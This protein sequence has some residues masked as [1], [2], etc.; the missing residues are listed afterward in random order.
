MQDWAL[1]IA[2]DNPADARPVPLNP[3]PLVAGQVRMR[4]ERFALTANN[5]TYATFGRAMR[6]WDFFPGDDGRGRLPVWG[7]ASVSES[8]HPDVTVGSRWYGYLPAASQWVM[9]PGDVSARGWTDVAEHRQPLPSVY[10]RYLPAEPQTLAAEQV[11]MV[12]QPLY[13]TAFLLDQVVAD[14]EQP[15]SGAQVLST[16]ASSKTAIAMA[17]CLA[18]REDVTHI[19]LTSA[20][21]V[22]FVEGLGL[23]DRV[24]AYDALSDLDARTPSVIVDFAGDSS[25]NRQLHSHL[26]GGLQ[27]NLRVGGAH[28]TASAPPKDLPPPK[29]TFFFAPDHV[30]RLNKAWGRETFESRYGAAWQA[31]ATWA[32]DAFAFEDQQGV[33]AVK[34]T[35]QRLIEGD[36]SPREAMTLVPAGE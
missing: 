15:W 4:I 9:T 30:L 18:Q 12:L 17:H 8:E 21:N 33:D 22:A 26:S 31:F 5:I 3:A 1:S 13:I 20:R 6:Y 25:L 34:A 11:R 29:P 32:T 14:P 19:G 7:I 28:W 23:Y 27:A 10:N 24:V 2:L 16:S 36:V 35:Y